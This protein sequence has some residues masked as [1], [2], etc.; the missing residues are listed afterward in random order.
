M[1]FYGIYIENTESILSLWVAACVLSIA[2]RKINPLKF[3]SFIRSLFAFFLFFRID[4]D[5][6]PNEDVL[7]KK[8]RYNTFYLNIEF[9]SG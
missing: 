2:Y 4:V 8:Q 9:Y 7:E 6:K 1:N 5:K 3:I